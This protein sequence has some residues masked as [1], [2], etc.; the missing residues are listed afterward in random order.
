MR[1]LVLSIDHN[2]QLAPIPQITVTPKMAENTTR[3]EAVLRRVIADRGVDL[4]CEE[5]NPCYASVAQMLAYQYSPRIP[6]RNIVMT[7]Q[8]RLEAGI[9]EASLD[10]PFDEV[11]IPP[12]SGNVQ[13]IHHRIPSDDVRE[14]FFANQSVQGGS[15][16]GVKSILVICG[17]M[18]ADFV[19]HILEESQFEAEVNHELISRKDWVA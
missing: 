6:W 13:T 2:W 7:A 4:I 19:K 14:R 11:E 1:F 9:Y 10:R 12:D 8:E 16:M 5:S 17:D 15:E 18:H 3:L